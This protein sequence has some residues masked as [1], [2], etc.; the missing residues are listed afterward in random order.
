[1]VFLLAEVVKEARSDVLIH[2]ITALFKVGYH[3]S[4][5]INQVFEFVI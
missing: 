3:V 4:K 1:M 5:L 2:R